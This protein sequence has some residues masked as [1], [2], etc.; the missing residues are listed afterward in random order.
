MGRREIDAGGVP[1][2]TQDTTALSVSKELGPSPP[3]Q[4]FMPGMRNSRAK[5]DV[6]PGPDIPADAVMMLPPFCV[7]AD[8]QASDDRPLDLGRV[9]SPVI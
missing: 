1:R 2:T 6:G 4:W 3:A 9:F 7:G 8:P 5:A